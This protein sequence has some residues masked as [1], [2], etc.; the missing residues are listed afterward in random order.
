M[1]NNFVVGEIGEQVRRVICE[2][3]ETVTRLRGEVG[4]KVHDPGAQSVEDEQSEEM[5]ERKVVRIP[6]E[7]TAAERQHHEDTGHTQYRDLCLHCDYGRTIGQPGF[8]VRE[9]RTGQ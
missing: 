4:E 6:M 2:I 7:P 9:D 3:G 1:A 5:K 8:K